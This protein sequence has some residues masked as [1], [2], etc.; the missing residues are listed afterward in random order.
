MW[1]IYAL[2]SAIVYS[3]R[4]V[5]EKLALNKVNPDILGFSIRFYSLPFFLVPFFIDSD[6]YIPIKELNL[7][8]WVSTFYIG[9]ISYPLETL[10]YYKAL[11]KDD[12]SLVLPILSIY[13][14]LTIV[15]AI[16]VL[17]EVPSLAGVLGVI[18]ITFGIY[19]L[20]IKHISDG[21]LAPIVNLK[22][23]KAV[24]YILIVVVLI[25]IGTVVDKIAITNGN[26][27]LY[28][29]YSHLLMTVP[30]FI[31]V[32]IRSRDKLIQIVRYYKYFG[33]IGLC[34][35]L[36][37]TLYLLAVKESYV[38]YASAVK[39]ASVLISIAF[40]IIL[41]KEKD[42]IS[43]VVAGLIITVGLILMKIAG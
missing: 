24:Q 21:L 19:M 1:F 29:L 18:V 27:Y 32:L 39:S 36:Y 31:F 33:V 8:F 3:F 23:N 42:I 28:A 2:G 15:L 35:F 11:Q 37:T 14:V 16:F 22:N 25:S 43:K 38:G 6:N 40:G 7:E 4:A 34:I 26:I 12:I 5:F 10:F 17:G 13:P 41:F 30:L 20:K 9:L